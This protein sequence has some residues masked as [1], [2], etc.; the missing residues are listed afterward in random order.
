M[1]YP[2]LPPEDTGLGETRESAVGF[3]LRL[4][5]QFNIFPLPCLT[6]RHSFRG[7]IVCSH[8]SWIHSLALLSAMIDFR[9]PACRNHH[10][11]DAVHIGG[12]HSITAKWKESLAL[13][14]SCACAYARFSLCSAASRRSR[15][16]AGK[17]RTSPIPRIRPQLSCST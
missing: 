3:D 8:V 10:C 1:P 9:M 12:G 4:V 15:Q 6:L 7:R 5:S 2:C 13:P 11:Q 17:H 14:M 16:H